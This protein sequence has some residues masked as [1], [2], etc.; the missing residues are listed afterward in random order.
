MLSPPALLLKPSL[1]ELPLPTD[2]KFFSTNLLVLASLSSHFPISFPSPRHRFSSHP[3]YLFL[4]KNPERKG[5]KILTKA[6]LASLQLC[7]RIIKD[8]TTS[9]RPAR[10]LHS[11]RTA[12][13]QSWNEN[14][15]PWFRYLQCPSWNFDCSQ[16]SNCKFDHLKRSWY[17]SELLNPRYWKYC[18]R[19]HP[20][21]EANRRKTWNTF[22]KLLEIPSQY[23]RWSKPSGFPSLY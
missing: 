5:K 22:F 8:V 17:F 6:I 3:F 21:S 14:L 12:N 15:V 10:L 18:G 9:A 19:L 23:W 16:H 1:Q 13:F 7:N 11:R 20:Y 2:Q 4:Q